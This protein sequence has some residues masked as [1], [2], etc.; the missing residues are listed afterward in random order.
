[1]RN[2]TARSNINGQHRVVYSSTEY[3]HTWVWNKQQG[4]LGVRFI[5]RTHYT[6]IDLFAFVYTLGTKRSSRRTN[7]TNESNGIYYGKDK[8]EKSWRE[9]KLVGYLLQFVLSFT[10]N[11]TKFIK[12]LHRYLRK[13]AVPTYN[14]YNTRHDT[15]YH[16]TLSHLVFKVQN[17]RI[18]LMY[19]FFFLFFKR[20]PV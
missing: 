15:K 3:D 18:K 12:V 20:C 17:V 10:F 14:I 19:F 4:D 13:I 16:R 11:S 8:T 2:I 9:G 7:K 5:Q 6:T 1:M